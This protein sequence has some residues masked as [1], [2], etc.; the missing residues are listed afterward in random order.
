MFACLRKC[1]EEDAKIFLPAFVML[2]SLLNYATFSWFVLVAAR[3]GAFLNAYS[4]L[5]AWEPI[6]EPSA[7]VL[8]GVT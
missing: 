8:L 2:P 6:A 4:V 7:T 3:Q 5:S 1:G